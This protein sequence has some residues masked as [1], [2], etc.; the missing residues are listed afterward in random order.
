MARQGQKAKRP[1]LEALAALFFGRLILGAFD[2]NVNWVHNRFAGAVLSTPTGAAIS[3][4]KAHQATTVYQI[5]L[6][7]TR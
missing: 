3:A 1:E 4:G 2:K 5:T 7:K 6:P